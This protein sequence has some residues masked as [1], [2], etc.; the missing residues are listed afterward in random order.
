MSANRLLAIGLLLAAVPAWGQAPVGTP[1]QDGEP[2]SIGLGMFSESLQGTFEVLSATHLRFT[3]SVEM[4][5]SGVKFFAD[6]V[7]YYTDTNRIVASGNVVFTNLEGSIAA[8][9]VEFDAATGLG[10][11]YEAA[12]I[13]SLGPAVDRSQFGGMDL[14]VYFFAEQLEK[15]GPRS[16]LLTDGGFSTCVQPTPRW[17]ITSGSITLHLDDYAV[18]R[19]TLL[20]VKGVPVFYL[21]VLYYPIRDSNR[22]TGFLMP[23]YGTST[24][25]GQAISNA[26]FWAIGRSQDAT[27]FHDWFTR[28]GQGAGT[29]YRYV[30]SPQSS[31][32]LRFYRFSQ[33]ET[34]FVEDGATTT[35]PEQVSYEFTGSLTQMVGPLRAQARVDYF[36]DITTQQLY[37]QD[38]YQASRRRR[39]IQG[40]VSGTRGPLQAG[41]L[42]ERTQ[43]FDN[44]DRSVLYGSTP[45]INASIAPSQ[46]FGTPVYASVSTEF[47]YLPYRF[48]RDTDVTRDDSLTRFD[49][50]PSVRV[51]L[52]QLSYLS[53]NTSASFRTT[54]YSQ[55]TAPEDADADEPYLRRFLNLQSEFIGPV[56]NRIFDTRNDFAERMKHVIEPTFTVDYTTTI[57]D[58]DRT[59][60]LSNTSDFII[61][62][63]TQ[64]TYGVT[65]RFFLRA[66]AVGNA[67]GQTRE[68]LTVGLQQ[69]YYSN[70]EASL[71]DTAYSSASRSRDAT[72]LSPIALTARLAPSNVLNA[73]A[74]FEYDVSGAG[75][76]VM[77]TGGTINSDLVSNNIRYSRRRYSGNDELTSYL[78]AT[79]STRLRDGALTG[80]YSFNWDIERGYLVS[81]T[82]EATY[83]AQCCG[84][85]VEFQNYSFEGR[86]GIPV[87]SDRRFNI[88][89]VLAG[90][91]TF[92]NFFGAFGG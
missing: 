49:L 20:R 32:D 33:Q 26:F 30:A 56:F 64:F 45:R 34:Q 37:N 8:D 69:T 38:L 39:L 3:D 31:G 54:Y 10:T 61:G 12:G 89:V 68:F 83:M 36:S 62:G 71:Y 27:F 75:L 79:T 72:D 59:P 43:T 44:D 50:A 16:Y 21:P 63:A 17:E 24:L 1:L 48:F 6:M 67:Q 74:R 46:L 14:D 78:T 42:Y 82:V 90:I 57:I 70:P 86:R 66:P 28:A 53:I 87:P 85:Q 15:T 76:M 52:S 58:L 65:N 80:S 25:R 29:E 60:I 88:G 81:Q 5:G 92:G 22:A 4:E 18:A 77:T 2:T 9:R 84:L 47:A 13:L 40:G 51:P 19:N 55:S 35:L 11:F 41:F 91:G 7:D 73:N 23:T